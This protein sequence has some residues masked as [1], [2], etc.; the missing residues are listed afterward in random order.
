VGD[1]YKLKLCGAGGGGF[2]LGFCKN[3]DKTKKEMAKSG[4]S[5]IPI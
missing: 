4:F 2:I 3:I 1:V 5:I